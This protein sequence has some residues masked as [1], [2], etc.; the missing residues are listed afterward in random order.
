MLKDRF[1]LVARRWLGTKSPLPSVF[2]VKPDGTVGATHRGYS[3]D[4]A[5]VLESEVLTAL[6]LM[7]AEK[8]D[9]HGVEY[10]PVR[11]FGVWSSEFGVHVIRGARFSEWAP[12]FRF[13]GPPWLWVRTH[14]AVR[15]HPVC[16]A[17]KSAKSSRNRFGLR[18]A[19]AARNR[20]ASNHEDDFPDCCVCC[21]DPGLW[22]TARRR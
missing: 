13:C 1:N 5:K 18:V 4:I 6:G 15:R 8:Q 19:Q 14:P 21:A 16:P 3:D 7:R 11:Q 22:W 9:Q 10:A 12:R 17:P 20:R 2:L